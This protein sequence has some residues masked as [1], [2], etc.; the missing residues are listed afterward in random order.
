MNLNMVFTK[1]QK[2]GQQSWY[3]GNEEKIRCKLTGM[4]TKSDKGDLPF[5]QISLDHWNVTKNRLSY[6]SSFL[7]ENKWDHI[8]NNCYN[9]T[10]RGF[11]KEKKLLYETG[12]T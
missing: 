12:K 9:R 1:K 8:E 4:E 3:V 5:H 2:L 7:P 11:C 10:R 6:F